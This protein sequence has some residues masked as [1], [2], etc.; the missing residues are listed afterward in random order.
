MKADWSHLEPARKTTGGLYATA[1]GEKQGV[2]YLRR[3]RTNFVVIASSGDESIPWEHVS[4]RA[5]DYKGERVP[6]WEEMCFIKAAFWDDE[7]CVVQFHPPRSEYVNNHPYV[8]H[9]WKPI[10][11]EMPRPPKIAVG[12]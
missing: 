5:I 12:V 9:L 2:F 6:T 4:V 3:V 8:L 7:E 1:T 11:L 10:G